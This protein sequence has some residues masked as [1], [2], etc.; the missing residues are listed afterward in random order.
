GPGCRD[1]V[2]HCVHLSQRVEASYTVPNVFSPNNDGLND[3][4]M[5]TNTGLKTLDCVIY[6]RW[7]KKIY[8]FDT[9]S[10]SWDGKSSGGQRLNDGTYYYV[11]KIQT[12]AGVNKQ[13]KG[14]VQLITGGM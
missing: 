6:D 8:E 2:T 4:F 7:G 3:L 11:L 10:G 14:F 9:P 1:S 5:I 12:E 13:E